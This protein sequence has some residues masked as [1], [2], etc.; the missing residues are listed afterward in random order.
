MPLVDISFTKFKDSKLIHKAIYNFEETMFDQIQRGES[1]SITI[2][3][4]IYNF[5]ETIKL[6][7]KTNDVNLTVP[8]NSTCKL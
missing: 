2:Q 4:D 6:I 3:K 1:H 7:R 5:K 8:T